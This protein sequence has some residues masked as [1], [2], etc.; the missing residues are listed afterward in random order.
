MIAERE[1]HPTRITAV[2][3]IDKEHLNENP[4]VPPLARQYDKTSRI[5]N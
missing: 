2:K 5:G 3:K 4:M 1:V